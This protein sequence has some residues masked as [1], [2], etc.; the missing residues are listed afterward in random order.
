MLNQPGSRSANSHCTIARAETPAARKTSSSSKSTCAELAAVETGTLV[1]SA[2]HLAGTDP[3]GC[4]VRRSC[5]FVAGRDGEPL[6]EAA[7]QRRGRKGKPP[8]TAIAVAGGFAFPGPPTGSS[9][10]DIAGARASGREPREH[11]PDP[12]TAPFIG[13]GWRIIQDTAYGFIADE[14]LSRG[15][16]IAFYTATSLRRYCSSS[17]RSPDWFSDK[18]LRRMRLP[19]NSLSWPGQNSNCYSSLLPTTLVDRLRCK[20]TS[21]FFFSRR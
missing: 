7:E 8:V 16:A 17:L 6:S 19:V 4:H 21:H 2:G 20:L 3:R 15:A 5:P 11:P 12:R 13:H 1:L 18:T 9:R 14:A 10:P